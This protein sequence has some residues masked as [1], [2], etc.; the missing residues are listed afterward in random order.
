MSKT[1]RFTAKFV[2]LAKNAVGG[3]REAAALQSGGGFADYAIFSLHCL[4]IYLDKSYHES[5]DL[6]REMPQALREIGLEKADLP[7]HYTLVK[8]FERI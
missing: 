4:W 3:R 5:L 2:T 1:S 8:T 6:L 7:H